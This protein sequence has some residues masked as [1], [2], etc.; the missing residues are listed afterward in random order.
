[1]T[2]LAQ[3]K[4]LVVSKRYAQALVELQNAGVITSDEI[5][6]DLKTISDTL[7]SSPNLNEVL[8]N[9]VTK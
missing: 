5:L 1:M 9:P 6:K 4:F 8:S 3:N 7:K 2:E